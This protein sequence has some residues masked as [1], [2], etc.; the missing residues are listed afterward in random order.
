MPLPPLAEAGVRP[1][2]ICGTEA[3]VF[4]SVDFNRSCEEARGLHLP[5]AG[6]A[7][8]YNRCPECGFLFTDAFAA[9]PVAAYE[10][11]I[12]NAG[13]AQIDPD[14]REARPVANARLFL[15]LFGERRRYLSVLDYGGGNGLFARLLRAYGFLC[16]ETYDPFSSEHDRMP[17]H[18]FDVVS[19]FET[20]EHVPDPAATVARIA[21]RLSTPGIVLFS[22]LLQPPDF[23]AQ[24]LG[25]WYAA[26]RNGHISLH[27]AQSLTR[28]WASVGF[29]CGSFSQGFHY[30]CRDI[31]EFSR[32][33]VRG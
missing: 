28:L 20:M 19:C 15:N 21:S 6:V 32:H 33:L 29:R 26:P 8:P 17:R 25:W 7:V 24:G 13:Y 31:P 22:T 30:A 2:K 14:Y 10:A 11:H 1:C 3:A 27:S 9:W 18:Q 12:Y 23:A 16:A 4:G 5:N